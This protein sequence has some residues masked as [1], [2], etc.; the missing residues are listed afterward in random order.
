MVNRPRSALTVKNNNFPF[1]FRKKVKKA[2]VTIFQKFKCKFYIWIRIQQL[3]LIWTTQINWDQC[4][5]GSEIL[6]VTVN[7]WFNQIAAQATSDQAIL[8]QLK[9]TILHSWSNNTAQLIKQYC[10]SWSSNTA[11]A[12]QTIQ[13]QLIK[14]YCNSWS[15]NTATADQAIL[16]CPLS[17]V[18]YFGTIIFFTLLT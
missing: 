14:Q 10:N 8:Q 11:T 15:S 5:S 18:V 9:K 1:F 7:R 16:G 17:G 2:I 6:L 13:Q 3:K 4:G 12:D